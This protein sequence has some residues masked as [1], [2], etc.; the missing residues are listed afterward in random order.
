MHYKDGT[1]AKAGDLVLNTT[2]YGGDGGRQVIGV[3]TSGTAGSTTCNG[4]ICP[5]ARRQKST[6]GWGPWLP[7]GCQTNDWSV[8]ISEC[9]KLDNWTAA[10]VEPATPPPAKEAQPSAA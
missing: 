8:T 9:E 1:P 7:L 5:V 2:L 4:N 6:L 10:P 3:L